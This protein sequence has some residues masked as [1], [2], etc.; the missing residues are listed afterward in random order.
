[1]F[2]FDVFSSAKRFAVMEVE[3]ASEFAPVKNA[4][5]KAA[6]DTPDTARAM[7]LK[8]H[9]SWIKKA[10]GKPKG[11][12][13]VDGALSFAGEGLKSFKGKKVSG[14]VG[15]SDDSASDSESGSESDSSDDSDDSESDSDES[16]S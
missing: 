12:V 11:D 2:I 14:H 16:S 9:A 6:T 13:E 10:G 15:G 7:V 4:N 5:D 8:L 1:M 3:R